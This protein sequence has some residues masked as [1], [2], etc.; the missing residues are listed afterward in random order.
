VEA[1]GNPWGIW[2]SNR[3]PIGIRGGS[4]KFYFHHTV[5]T[6]CQQFADYMLEK[7]DKSTHPFLDKLSEERMI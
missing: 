7:L 4:V 6:D 2:E 3:N 1:I 5:Q